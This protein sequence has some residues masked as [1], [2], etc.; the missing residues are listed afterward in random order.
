MDG[1][2]AHGKVVELLILLF[3]GGVVPG[4]RNCNC[5]STVAGFTL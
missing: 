5:E 4:M 2:P 3:V 1:G